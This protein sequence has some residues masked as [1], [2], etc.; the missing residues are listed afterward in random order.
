M[1]EKKNNLLFKKENY[2]YMI[3]GVVFIMMGFIIMSGGGSHDPSIF[4]DEIYNFR[5]IR[6]AP[7]L[8]LI[9]FAIQ[10]YAILKSTKK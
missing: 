10:V 7:A 6:L 1:K 5:R 3:I 4:K 9:G 8:I 2:K